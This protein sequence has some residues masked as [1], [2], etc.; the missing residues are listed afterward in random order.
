MFLDYRGRQ[1]TLDGGIGATNFRGT[2]ARVWVWAH[3]IDGQRLMTR[4]ARF[5][6]K[7]AKEFRAELDRA[8]AAA[9]VAEVQ[10]QEAIA[11]LPPMD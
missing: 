7:T 9:E 8:I 3:N 4:S 1:Y 5:D 10:W 6:L 2:R 11:E